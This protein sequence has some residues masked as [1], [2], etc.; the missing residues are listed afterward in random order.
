VTIW[1]EGSYASGKPTIA[2]PEKASEVEWFS[3]R[4]L[5]EPRFISLQNLV[6]GKTLPP[7]RFD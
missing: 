6:D 5:P 2:E 7:V 4:A 3:W 1:F